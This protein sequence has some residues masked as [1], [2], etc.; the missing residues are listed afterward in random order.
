ME[1][2][3][4]KKIKTYKKDEEKKKKKRKKIKMKGHTSIRLF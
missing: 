4:P 2:L 1:K 3:R